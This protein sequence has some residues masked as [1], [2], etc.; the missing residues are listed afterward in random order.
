ML[1]SWAS[2][3]RRNPTMHPSRKPRVPSGCRGA[4]NAPSHISATDFTENHDGNLRA[5][6]QRRV[7]FSAVAGRNFQVAAA[8][9]TAFRI[10][11]SMSCGSVGVTLPASS[12]RILT[13][14]V[15][16]RLSNPFG[17]LGSSRVIK[18]SMAFSGLNS[19]QPF[20]AHIP[21]YRGKLLSNTR[22]RKQ[23]FRLMPDFL[24]CARIAD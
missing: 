3:G 9:M 24:H 13:C 12:I 6:R 20:V 1:I 23:F 2:H 16:G 15:T 10:G 19:R 22:I 5:R 17:T 7:S 4:R 14:T 18:R 8:A 21:I 11:G